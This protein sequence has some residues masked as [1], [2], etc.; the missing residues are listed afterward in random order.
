MISWP[1]TRAIS[2]TRSLLVREVCFRLEGTDRLLSQDQAAN[3]MRDAVDQ[4][5]PRNG[6]HVESNSDARVVVNLAGLDL[7]G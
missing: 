6:Y 7:A 1:P 3:W 5:F 4:G 2:H